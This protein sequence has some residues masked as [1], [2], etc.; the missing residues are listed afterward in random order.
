VVSVL[1]AKDAGDMAMKE[2]I[3]QNGFTLEFHQPVLDELNNLND[4]IDANELA[5]RKDYRDVLTFTI[6]P[7]DAKDF[8]D[9]V[10]NKNIK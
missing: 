9:A 7:A 10:V 4:T 3:I 6:D 8:D 2:I 5:K 1:Q